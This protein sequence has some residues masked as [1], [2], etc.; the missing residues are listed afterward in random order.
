VQVLSGLAPDTRIVASGGGFLNDG[1]LV[2]VQGA[3]ASAT[4]AATAGDSGTR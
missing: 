2:R 1:D 4:P 3:P